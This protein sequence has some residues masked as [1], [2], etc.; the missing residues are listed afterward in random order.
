[1]RAPP[2]EPTAPFV[3]AFCAIWLAYDV[4]DV[5]THGSEAITGAYASRS[6]ARLLL[7]LQLGLVVCE[8]AGLAVRRYRLPLAGVAVLRTAEAV[9]CFHLNDFY[10]CALTAA[11]LAVDVWPRSIL[12][13]Q[14][15]WIYF[16][17]A[18]LKLNTGWLSGGH[19]YVRHQYLAVVQHWPYPGFYRR[20]VDTLPGNAW[21]AW[22]GVALE[23]ALTLL[24]ACGA[25]R[26]WTLPVAAGIHLFGALAMNVWFFGASMIAQVAFVSGRPRPQGAS[27]A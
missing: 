9:A 22:A 12:R 11:I 15:A 7:G 14:T 4:L 20:W 18:L 19:L 21:L 3:R 1:M 26:R 16:A 2:G 24:L 27:S 17:T 10:A 8:A 23:F 5:L 13:W 25:R 6:A